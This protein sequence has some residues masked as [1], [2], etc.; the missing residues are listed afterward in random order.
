MMSPSPVSAGVS[1]RV[2]LG[3]T[4]AGVLAALTACASD[5]RPLADS[6]PLR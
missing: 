4:S 5:I 2:A 6:S 3:A 1:R